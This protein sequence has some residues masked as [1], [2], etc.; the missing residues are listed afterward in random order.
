MRTVTIIELEQAI[1]KARQAQPAE[2]IESTLPRD[3]ARLADVYGELIF[4]GHK[5]FDLDSL[6]P[7]SKESLIRWLSPN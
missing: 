2:G 7:P 5:A 1:N 6:T 3:V 4:S